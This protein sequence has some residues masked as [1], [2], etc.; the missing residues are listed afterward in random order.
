MP[1]N[2]AKSTKRETPRLTDQRRHIP[3]ADADCD[4]DG[5]DARGSIE[6]VMVA[7]VLQAGVT[8]YHPIVAEG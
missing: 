6:Q 3:E 7:M 4:G 1:G 5:A 8:T 2:V